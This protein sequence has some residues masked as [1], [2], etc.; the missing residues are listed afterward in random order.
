MV[1]VPLQQDRARR[2]FRSALG[3]L[4]RVYADE[5]A[6]S[7]L[8]A[9]DEARDSSRAFRILSGLLE[10][11]YPLR[12]F[13]E[14]AADEFDPAIGR[15]G[16]H[17][18]CLRIL[19]KTS[20]DWVFRIPR[21][22]EQILWSA[23]VLFYGNHPSMLTPFLV[24]AVVERE[25]LGIMSTNYVRRLLPSFRPFAFTFE[26][27]LTRSWTEWRRGGLRRVLAYR[28]VNLLHTVPPPEEA[29]AINQRGLRDG[30]AHVRAGGCVL[31]APGG[32][33]KRDRHWFS[34]IGI[35]ARELVER[36][37][38]APAYVVPVREENSSNHRV[39]A[40]LMRGPIA[41]AKCAILHRHPVRITF[42]AP[43]PIS[44]VV[45]KG[46]TVEDA[47]AALRAHYEAQFPSA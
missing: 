28:L 26:V 23:P 20:I 39:Y 38:P 14:L 46:S 18:G 3:E 44:E 21:E 11:I 19:S 5:N 34:G 2:S 10:R 7:V 17:R 40:H 31:I 12:T 13:L 4:R 1:Q 35:L 6:G 43:S 16:L 29:K 25:D 22:H 37:G 33:G 36:P 42:A 32:G 15:E 27:P 45:G 30:A 8:V 41:R 24:A 47:V 9:F